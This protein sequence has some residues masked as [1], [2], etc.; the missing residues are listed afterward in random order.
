MHW[1]GLSVCEIPCRYTVM[2]TPIKSARGWGHRETEKGRKFRGFQDF[3][4]W[5][6]EFSVLIS[7]I[8]SSR[9][10]LPLLCGILI[11]YYTTPPSSH[12]VGM[13]VLHTSDQVSCCVYAT[14]THTHQ[15]R[16]NLQTCNMSHL[17][18]HIQKHTFYTLLL[19]LLCHSQL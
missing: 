3:C 14:H 15:M 10:R 16:W 18:I 1:G 5:A 12:P 13:A 6:E 4:L 11:P 17:W 19:L 2:L 8:S 7:L 9:Q